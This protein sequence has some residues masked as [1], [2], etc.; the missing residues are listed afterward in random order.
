MAPCSPSPC[1]R[2]RCPRFVARLVK[3]RHALVR[4]SR[5][6][7]AAV[8]RETAREAVWVGCIYQLS[9]N[10]FLFSFQPSTSLNNSLR[11]TWPS[12]KLRLRHTHTVAMPTITL[13]I[14]LPHG[15]SPVAAINASA[16]IDKGPATSRAP[17]KRSPATQSNG[18]THAP[19]SHVPH[20]H[21]PP[22]PPTASSSSTPTT[23]TTTTVYS[24][25]RLRLTINPRKAIDTPM[26]DPNGSDEALD[27]I[28]SATVYSRTGN[29]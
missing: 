13:R 24:P 22:P 20:S 18:Y 1:A 6:A 7:A 15:P 26:N 21:H 5:A 29:N 2:S 27:H 25:K 23:T 11:A 19:R 4:H 8:T 28:L 9:G 16:D 17:T 12:V 3:R 14:P 10:H